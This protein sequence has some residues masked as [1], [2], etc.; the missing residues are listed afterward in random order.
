VVFR[1][2][3][4]IV[5]DTT[6]GS[7]IYLTNQGQSR[8]KIDGDGED[9][10]GHIAVFVIQHSVDSDSQKQVQSAFV[11]SDAGHGSD[12]Q[13]RSTLALGDVAG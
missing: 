11:L 13:S 9:T 3:S 7:D 10:A 6:I 8:S 5:S 12:F 1:D 4:S 2:P